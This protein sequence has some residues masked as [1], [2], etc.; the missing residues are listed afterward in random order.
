MT[1]L[2]QRMLALMHDP[3]FCELRRMADQS[4][5]PWVEFCKLD[6]PQGYTAEETWSIFSAI[7]R[8]TSVTVPI[9]SY[10]YPNK[11][12]DVWYVVNT[13]MAAT[14]KQIESL[15]HLPE[16]ESNPDRYLLARHACVDL[17]AA[18]RFDGI[19]IA[20]QRIEEMLVSGEPPRFPEEYIAA[21]AIRLLMKIDGDSVPYFSYWFFRDLIR[22][23]SWGCERL[24]CKPA[25]RVPKRDV[26]YADRYANTTPEKAIGEICELAN[27]HTYGQFDYALIA[28]GLISNTLLNLEPLEKWNGLAEL[29]SRHMFLERSG[30]HTLRWVP[31]S[32]L[33][34]RWH[35][36]T[37]APPEVPCRATDFD[38]NIG[39]GLD[40][41][42]LSYTHLRLIL[43]GMND[44]VEGLAQKRAADSAIMRAIEEYPHL[45]YRQRLLLREYATNPDLALKIEPHRKLYRIAYCTARSDF[46]ELVK[47]GLLADTYEGKALV[48]RRSTE[49]LN[50][51]FT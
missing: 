5:L 17:A 30:Y 18:L 36:E 40:H 12:D 46:I 23:L 39:E 7:R 50:R 21:N 34:E 2:V 28:M 19:Y 38:P 41:T 25:P 15:A 51:L 14:I 1:E 44:L 3:V 20:E 16:F 4:A 47:R 43:I 37:I 48:F 9:K 31:F 22:Q 35:S 42:S 8:Q 33:I 29:I 49:L 13:A 45:N 27:R 32:S 24:A 10:V 11:A 26:P 6:M